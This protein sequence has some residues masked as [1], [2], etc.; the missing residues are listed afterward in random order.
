[1]LVGG[2]HGLTD[3]HAARLSD[4]I[5]LETPVLGVTQDESGVTLVSGAGPVSARTVIV[6]LPPTLAGRLAYDPAMPPERDYLTQRMPI[7]GKIAVAVL[8]D[9][10]FWRQANVDLVATEDLVMWDEGGEERPAA[11]S[12]LVSIAR[13]RELWALSPAGR[14]EAILQALAKGLGPRAEKPVGYHEVYWA[15][16]PWCRGCNSFMT[17]GAWTAWGQALRRPVG[18]VHWAGA[19]TSP[20]FVGQMEGA[21]Q[22]AEAAVE[23]VIESLG[24]G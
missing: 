3:R 18:R 9:E 24:E 14:R 1:M 5:A 8:Y 17:T 20:R 16:E 13:S 12:G 23:A 15:A 11:Y 22:S 10:P 2:A 7:R 4:A 19:E 6:T 21:V